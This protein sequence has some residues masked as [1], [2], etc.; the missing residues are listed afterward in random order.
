M[1]RVFILML[2]AIGFSTFAVDS[3]QSI[4]QAK[5][6]SDTSIVLSW[7]SLPEATQYRIFYDE[8][9]LLDPLAPNPLL[10]S[11][12]IAKNE[13]T[14]A[15]LAP[16]TDYT[17]IVHGYNA[18]DHEVGR[19]LP[20]HAKTYSTTP[21]MNL[22]RDPFAVSDSTVELVF[23]RP[24]DVKSVQISLRN[25]KTK[26][27]LT[28][29]EIVSSPEDLRVVTIALQDMMELSVPYEL[30]LKKVV[31]L[32]GEE[33]PPESRTP[34]KIAYSGGLPPLAGADTPPALDVMDEVPETAYEEPVAID[35]LPQT[36]PAAL[37][38]L[39]LLS[40]LIIFLA[41]KKLSKRA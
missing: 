41:Q 8:S 38:I 32:A 14:L 30:T 17:I 12:P 1:H 18:Q 5:K 26:K 34:L 10:D 13:G 35:R 4:L 11:D 15:K 16:A 3:S 31:S 20:L 7:E 39:A 33:L 21:L 25:P 27:N 9:D 22:A 23:T 28:I 2:L 29:K 37:A 36:G 40:A 19:T 24:I 6:I